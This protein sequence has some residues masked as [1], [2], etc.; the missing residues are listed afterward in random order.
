MM[1]C[2]VHTLSSYT[3]FNEHLGVH[4]SNSIYKVEFAKKKKKKK[5]KN[6]MYRMSS[7]IPRQI[8]NGNLRKSTS[9]TSMETML[10]SSCSYNIMCVH[11][12][13]GEYVWC[14]LLPPLSES[15]LSGCSGGGEAR[16]SGDPPPTPSSRS[17]TTL[18]SSQYCPTSSAFNSGL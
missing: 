16:F 4:F 2:F 5:R 13:N 8:E 11:Y 17:L 7:L 15:A 14:V 3:V 6:C 12:T 1:K 9:F 10:L 18:T